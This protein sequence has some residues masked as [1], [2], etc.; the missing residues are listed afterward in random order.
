M[1]ECFYHQLQR[2]EP[3]FFESRQPTML[4]LDQA[5]FGLPDSEPEDSRVVDRHRLATERAEF[6]LG[7]AA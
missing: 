2:L 6:V 3:G 1:G 7:E 5:K 4:L